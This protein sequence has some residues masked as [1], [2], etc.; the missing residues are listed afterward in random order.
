MRNPKLQTKVKF[1]TF[2]VLSWTF[3]VKIQDSTKQNVKQW[4][5]AKV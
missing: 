3:S 5:F 1:R 2:S 4:F